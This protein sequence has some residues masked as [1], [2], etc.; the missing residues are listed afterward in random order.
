MKIPTATLFGTSEID[1]RYFFL[2]SEKIGVK[3]DKSNLRKFEA[4]KNRGNL[5]I[6]RKILKKYKIWNRKIDEW[7]RYCKNVN[8]SAIFVSI[9]QL[10]QPDKRFKWII[11]RKL[12]SMF[13][14]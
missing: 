3:K 8:P 10:E 4:T 1:R 6:A 7:Y 5:E 13:K 11:A 12:N 14:K 2:A 9:Y